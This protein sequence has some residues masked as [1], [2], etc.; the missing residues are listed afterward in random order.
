MSDLF[1]TLLQPFQFA[2][3]QQAFVIAI[4]VAAPMASGMPV[5]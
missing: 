4:L 5:M 1:Q 2:F 3:M